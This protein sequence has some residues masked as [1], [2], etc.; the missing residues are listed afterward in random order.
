MI[1]KG[2]DFRGFELLVKGGIMYTLR[3]RNAIG[4]RGDTRQGF[5]TTC[6]GGV[7]V[8]IKRTEHGDGRGP[9]LCQERGG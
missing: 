5:G 7:S 6:P 2:K 4:G 9:S 1:I 8:Q 3:V